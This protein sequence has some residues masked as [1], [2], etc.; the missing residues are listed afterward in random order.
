[1]PKQIGSVLM[2]N[3][4][5]HRQVI[6]AVLDYVRCAGPANLGGPATPFEK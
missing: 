1:M 3:E 6:E 2:P 4:Q 5:T